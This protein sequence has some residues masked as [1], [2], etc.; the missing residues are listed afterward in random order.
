MVPT[1]KDLTEQNGNVNLIGSWDAVHLNIFLKFLAGQINFNVFMY[2]L[3]IMFKLEMCIRT[4]KIYIYLLC[5][6]RSVWYFK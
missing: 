2:T 1:A 3:K 6:T 4:L 5:H